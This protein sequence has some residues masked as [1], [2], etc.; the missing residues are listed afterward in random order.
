MER[1]Y[2]L[3]LR[4]PSITRNLLTLAEI[5]RQACVHPDLVERMVDLGLIEPEQYSPE[6]LFR[7][8]SVG[9]VCRACRL[10]N[11]LGI[12]WL[13]IGVVMDLLERI[14]QLEDEIS[15]LRRK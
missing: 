12:N 5:A 3:M 2:Y 14:V 15:R 13:G 4:R 1:R 11:D 9:D 10:R 8:E 7:P 6:I